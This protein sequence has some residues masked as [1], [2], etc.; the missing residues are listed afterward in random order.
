MRVLSSPMKPGP[1][2]RQHLPST[3]S[4]SSSPAHVLRPGIGMRKFLR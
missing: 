3:L 1:A 4:S 2:F